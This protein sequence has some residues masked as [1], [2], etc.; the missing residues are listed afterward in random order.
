MDTFLNFLN[1]VPKPI[2]IL[3]SY[4]IV[5]G[6]PGIAVGFYF[7]SFFRGCF[8]TVAT[9]VFMFVLTVT[10]VAVAH[11]L[12]KNLGEAAEQYRLIAFIIAVPSGWLLGLILPVISFRRKDRKQAHQN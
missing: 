4:V 6:I 11:L 10:A 12:F 8:V 5:F 3:I 1:S 2:G 9:F 7:K